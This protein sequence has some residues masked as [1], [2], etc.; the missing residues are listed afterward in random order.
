MDV[1]FNYLL[2]VM[3]I[4]GLNYLLDNVVT[5]YLFFIYSRQFQLP[6]EAVYGTSL[7]RLT[8]LEKQFCYMGIFT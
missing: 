5:C 3:C 6:T 4:F 2:N 7:F 8:Y 1:E